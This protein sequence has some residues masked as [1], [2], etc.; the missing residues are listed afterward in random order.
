LIT[1]NT[2]ESLSAHSVPEMLRAPLENLVL[3]VKAMHLKESLFD[4]LSRC[5]DPPLRSSIII[6]ENILKSIQALD[7]TGELTSLGQHLSTLPCDPKIGRLLVYGALFGCTYA[8]SAVGACLTNR[9][10]FITSPSNSTEAILKESAKTMF[11]KLSGCHSD[12]TAMAQAVQMFSEVTGNA[13]QKKFCTENGLYYERMLEIRTSQ[14][15][16]LE[17]LVSLGL[18]PSVLE[19]LSYTSTSNRNR[20]KPKIIIAIVCAGLYPSVGKIKRPPLRYVDTQGGKIEKNINVKELNFF[21]LKNNFDCED[22]DVVDD[23]EPEVLSTNGLEEVYLHQSS[24]NATNVIFKLSNFILYTEKSLSINYSK[25]NSSGGGGNMENMDGFLHDISEV[26]P[27]PLLLFGG[28]LE[29]QYSDGTVSIDK[30]IKFTASKKI[31]K[32][33]LL[34]RNAIDQLLYE[35]INNTDYDMNSSRILEVV[36]HLLATDGLNSFIEICK[37]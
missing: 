9:S 31:L 15:D 2:F 23:E 16:L 37:F 33:I 20:S 11:S 1:F 6:A 30:W 21:I 24:I 35:K 28:L 17:G 14:K 26:S 10:P 32:I 27:M 4:L 5:P 29:A 22:N 3:Q 25:D 7:Q 13:N 36:C 19:G 12:H 18:L 8:A 34:L